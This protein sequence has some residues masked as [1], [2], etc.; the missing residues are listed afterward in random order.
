MTE[1]LRPRD[2]VLHA[3][4]TLPGSH[5]RGLQRLTRL[6]FG[7]LRYH[8]NALVQQH[9]IR[10]EADRRFLRYYP[11]GMPAATRRTWDALRSRPTRLIARA[12]LEAPLPQG[13]LAAR[14]GLA[15][16]TMHRHAS[17]LRRLGVVMDNRDSLQLAWP[18]ETRR[19]LGSINPRLLDDLTDGAISLFDQ[20]DR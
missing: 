8:A 19:L 16:S 13:T 3:V 4:Q 20:L 1:V 9:A 18:E 2:L 14:L 10:S 7:T 12:L 6:A 15:A 11:L 17:H 5:L